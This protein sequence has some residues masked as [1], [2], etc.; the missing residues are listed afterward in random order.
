[1]CRKAGT[2]RRPTANAGAGC[3][4]KRWK[5]RLRERTRC[6][7]S[8][9]ISCARSSAARRWRTKGATV[10]FVFRNGDG[11]SFE[12]HEVLVPKLLADVKAF[13]KSN[14]R[15]PD[16][17]RRNIANIGWLLVARNQTRYVGEKV[18]SWE[19]KLEPREH[20]F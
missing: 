10:D 2:M 1:M 11:V 20:H 5:P 6:C 3:S 7:T 14:P 8:L 13:L 12:A 9:R 16:D 4:R 18:A 15:H 17:E 19:L